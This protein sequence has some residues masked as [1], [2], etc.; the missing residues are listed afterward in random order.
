MLT[1][2]YENFVLSPRY[3][4]ATYQKLNSILGHILTKQN[5]K[6][7]GIESY[8]VNLNKESK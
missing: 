8:R 1:K 7:E 3:C 6:I 5:I 4:G 2:N